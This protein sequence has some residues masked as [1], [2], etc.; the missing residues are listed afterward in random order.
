MS[1]F[2]LVTVAPPPPLPAYQPVHGM[3]ATLCYDPRGRL[4]LSGAALIMI[5][6]GVVLGYAPKRP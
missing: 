2:Q 5:A 1:P 4:Y 3:L 6:M